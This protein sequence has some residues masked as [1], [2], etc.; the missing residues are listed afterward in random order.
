MKVCPSQRS[1]L[2]HLL[3][4]ALH[5]R[6]A[7]SCFVVTKCHAGDSVTVLCPVRL[8]APRWST[9]LIFAGNSFYY[10]GHQMVIFQLC[11]YF[12]I[13]LLHFLL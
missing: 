11:Y 9:L 5:W 1:E 4:V 10:D 8:A 7:V 13:Y 6:V 12:C 2:H 3:Q